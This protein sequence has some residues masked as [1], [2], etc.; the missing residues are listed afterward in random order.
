MF[1]QKQD[2]REINA[3]AEAVKCLAHNQPDWPVVCVTMHKS[4]R[5]R[6]NLADFGGYLG[7]SPG[8]SVHFTRGV[9][10]LGT[11]PF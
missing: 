8:Q 3:E 6:L 7:S 1:T 9:A 5:S 4:S 11:A 2:C 10:L